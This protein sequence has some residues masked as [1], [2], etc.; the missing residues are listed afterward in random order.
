MDTQGRWFYLLK[1]G[2]V[3]ACAYAKQ[4]PMTSPHATRHTVTLPHSRDKHY[5]PRSGGIINTALIQ[6]SERYG[7]KS[8]VIQNLSTDN[9]T[10]WFMSALGTISGTV[11][12]QSLLFQKGDD[13]TSRLD[14]SWIL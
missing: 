12:Y 7:I 5:S 10:C 8:V 2:T 4:I 11:C 13:D 14:Q 6:Y 1:T 9:V 3:V